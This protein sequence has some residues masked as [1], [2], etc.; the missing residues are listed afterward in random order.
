MSA[1][2]PQAYIREAI[3]LLSLSRHGKTVT[4]QPARIIPS[5]E[6]DAV[7]LNL[8]KAIGELE[9]DI[10]V[11]DALPF[12][13]WGTRNFGTYHRQVEEDLTRCGVRVPHDRARVC[14]KA[15]NSSRPS[16]SCEKCWTEQLAVSHA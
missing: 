13:A 12:V 3:R 15:G 7:A 11:N 8:A 5:D 1:E 2:S 9:V 10:V 16:D 14:Y 4:G 6:L